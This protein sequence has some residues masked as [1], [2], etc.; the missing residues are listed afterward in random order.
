MSDVDRLW[1]RCRRAVRNGTN[2]MSPALTSMHAPYSVVAR[3]VSRQRQELAQQPRLAGARL[4]TD[5][6][7][8]RQTCLGACQRLEKLTYLRLPPHEVRTDQRP[9][10]RSSIGL[11]LARWAMTFSGSG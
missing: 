2:G 1:T 11:E 10:H 4:A 8:A 6:D 9:G 3:I 5:Q 7:D